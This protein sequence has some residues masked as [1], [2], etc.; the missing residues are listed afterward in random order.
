MRHFGFCSLFNFLWVIQ[1]CKSH[2]LSVSPKTRNRTLPAP[3]KLLF[4]AHSCFS[5]V[6]Q[7]SLNTHKHSRHLV[8]P[9]LVTVYGGRRQSSVAFSRGG[10]RRSRCY[11]TAPARAVTHRLYR[12]RPTA[13]PETPL[14]QGQPVLGKPRNEGMEDA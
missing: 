9:C 8:T 3:Q 13:V 7:N 12:V 1:S 4:R 6:L 2:S 11:Q 14:R 10:Y 5:L